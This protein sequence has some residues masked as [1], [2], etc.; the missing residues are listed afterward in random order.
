MRAS[1]VGIVLFLALHTVSAQSDLKRGVEMFEAGKFDSAIVYLRRSLDEQETKPAYIL[2]THT[3]KALGQHDTAIM[4]GHRLIEMARREGDSST[5]ANYWYTVGTVYRDMGRE[6]DAAAYFNRGAAVATAIGD[7]PLAVLNYDSEAGVY[8]RKGDYKTALAILDIALALALKA[9]D[10]DAVGNVLVSQGEIY[11]ALERYDD[12]MAAFRQAVQCFGQT[13]QTQLYDIAK[14]FLSQTEAKAGLL[15]VQSLTSEQAAQN[16]D[17]SGDS[18]AI[19]GSWQDLKLQV[20]TSNANAKDKTMKFDLLRREYLEKQVRN[21]WFRLWLVAALIVM[22]GVVAVLLYRHRIRLMR[23]YIDGLE[24]E[25]A[26]ISKELHDGICND[27]L[28]I[29]MQLNGHSGIRQARE[30]VRRLSHELM[31]PAFQYATIDEIL[32]DYL[33]RQEV[34]YTS[35]AGADYHSVPQKSAFELYRI[36]QEAVGNALKHAQADTIEVQL[37]LDASKLTLTVRDNGCGMEP[38]TRPRLVKER[39]ESIGGS[40]GIESDKNGTTLTIT[41]R[42]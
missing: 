9:D 40:L 20:L 33:G 16:L 19:P 27:L 35:T 37:E 6:E 42:I 8:K 14:T 25:R 11:D 38:G 7:Y 18:L 15:N 31:P 24:S 23:R 32:R 36:V 3:Y 12:A 5:V 41:V 21:L 28:A 26:R 13:G 22:A 34:K 39:V 17:F 2:L 30:N 29:E 4:Y 10:K 1:F